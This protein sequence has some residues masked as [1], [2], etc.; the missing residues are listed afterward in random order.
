MEPFEVSAHVSK[1]TQLTKAVALA[2]RYK[3]RRGTP[4]QNAYEKMTVEEAPTL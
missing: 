3:A 4:Q 2:K 1:S